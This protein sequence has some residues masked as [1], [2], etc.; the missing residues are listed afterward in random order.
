ML[1]VDVGHLVVE[2]LHHMSSVLLVELVG[3]INIMG[4][5]YSNIV[6]QYGCMCLILRFIYSV[7][8]GV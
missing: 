8:S 5:F 7:I 4:L 2:P 1:R 6:L 3:Y